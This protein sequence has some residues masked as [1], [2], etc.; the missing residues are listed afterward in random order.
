M[1]VTSLTAAGTGLRRQP[2]TEKIT[3]RFLVLVLI[4]LIAAPFSDASEISVAEFLSSAKDAPGLAYQAEK[5]RF[6]RNASPDTPL[7]DRVEFRTQTEEFDSSQQR[8]A[9]RFVPNGWGETDADTDV[10]SAMLRLSEAE[11]DLLRL[12]ALKERSL[13]VV[14]FLHSQT[15]LNVKRTL[16][17]ISDDRVNVLRKSMEMPDTD[18][19][20]LVRAGDAGMALKLEVMA[21]ESGIRNLERRIKRCVASDD[22]VGFDPDDLRDIVSVRDELTAWDKTASCDNIHLRKSLLQANLA[23]RRYE[24]EKTE[25]KKYIRYVEAAYESRERDDFDK[26]FSLEI[27][28]QLPG[29]R[30][31][32]TDIDR[33]R[34]E[35]L[36]LQGEHTELQAAFSENLNLLASEIS[37][38]F[39]QFDLL[40]ERKNANETEKLLEAHMAFGGADPLRLLKMKE[41]LL[42]SDI[43]LAD[44]VYEI[45]RKYIE[46][47]DIRGALSEKSL[48][49]VDIT[50]YLEQVRDRQTFLKFVRMLSA[51][52]RPDAGTA[53]E[54]CSCREGAG[55]EHRP[56]KD[57]VESALA[58]ADVGREE[59]ADRESPWKAFAIFLYCGKIC[60]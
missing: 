45:Y 18:L 21:L 14:D 48:G 49:R 50:E 27:G 56:V 42:N 35:F 13:L 9:L 55:W 44:I 60:E 23:R 37:T 11:Y 53:P 26:A 31:G 38:L 5:I 16:L 29:I 2:A 8:Y 32:R 58:R 52:Q 24:L 17:V 51:G 22:P 4:F 36:T 57:F 25:N 12:R 10:R 59:V 34:L 15:V 3:A 46:W 47:L 6:F 20:D 40:A 28:L 41:S 39:R 30:D 7:L 33:R 54:I 43:R 1:T 19:S